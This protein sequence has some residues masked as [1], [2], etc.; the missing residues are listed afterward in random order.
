[1]LTTARKNGSLSYLN[2]ER[3][4]ETNSGIVTIKGI[5]VRFF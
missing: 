1:M 4:Q 2:Y 3:W 5:F